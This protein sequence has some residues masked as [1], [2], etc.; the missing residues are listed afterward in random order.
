MTP[1]PTVAAARPAAAFRG[2]VHRASPNPLGAADPRQEG[3]PDLRL[4]PPALTAWAAAALAPALPALATAVA[5]ASCCLLASVLAFRRRRSTDPPRWYGNRLVAAMTLI[6]AAAGA[7]SAALHAVDA[8]R[9]PVPGLAADHATTSVE[10]T[11]TGDPHRAEPRVIGTRRVPG[12]LVVPV[13][14][15]RVTVP[16]TAQHVAVHTPALL[17]VDADDGTASRWGRLLPSTGI[18]V[19]ARFAPPRPRGG[20]R[21]VAAVLRTGGKD[22]PVVLAPPTTPQRVAGDLRAGLREA[23]GELAPD[24]RALLPGLVVGDTSRIPEDLDEAF[25]TT[26]MLHLLAVS[27]GNLTVLLVLLIGPPGRASLAERRGLAPRLGLPLRATAV[28]AAL[29]VLGFVL[30][31]RPQPSVLRAAACGLITILAIGT[32]RR[33]SLIPALAAA[34]LLLVLHDPGLAR[35][36]GFLLSVL[37]TGSLLT[38]APRWSLALRR[39]GIPGRLAEALAAAAAAQ[40]ACA[41]VVAVLAAHISLVA[42]PCNLLAEFAV[43][44]ATVLGF[45]ALLAAPLSPALAEGL[46]RLGGLPAAAIALIARTGASVPGATFPWPDTWPGA[47]LLALLVGAMLIL[48]RRLTAHPWL[49]AAT[50]LLLLLALVR[51]APLTR[52]LTGWPP[53]GWLLVTCDVGQGDAIVLAA[54]D[55][56][57]A[58]VDTG[59]EPDAVDDCLTSLGVTRIPFLLLTHFHADHVAGLPGALRGRTVGAIR[60]TGVQEPSAQA[61]FVHRVAR[62][63]GVPLVRAAAGGRGSLGPLSWQVVWPPAGRPSSVAADGEDVANNASVTLLVRVAGLT[64]LLPGD[65]EPPAQRRLLEDLPG[66]GPV[67]V[68]KVAHHGSAYQDP[69]LLARLDP[70]IALISAGTGNPYGHPSPHTLRRLHH[71]GALVRRT[72]TS[73]PL[74]V[75]VTPDGT[76]AVTTARSPPGPRPG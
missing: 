16:A 46:A 73:G 34:V 57:A 67:D 9:G 75:T 58:L 41:P 64:V 22:P 63:A 51:P 56:T 27:G 31:C 26:D 72:D 39:H 10:L 71:R 76:P 68:L 74:A 25:H 18:R 30:V 70:R 1:G 35:E 69:A 28:L 59:P 49:C 43:A 32:G 12:V 4:V 42:V 50:A 23:T 13:D 61:E 38:V 54:G 52:P 36:A 7:A 29:V 3:P 37:A 2:P 21:D 5:V 44:P 45:A 53:D 66:L 55:G 48:G 14:V 33:R 20:G 6:C 8:R 19:E 40:A 24:P 47:L 60:A 17:L 62:R 15:T 11:V 65:L